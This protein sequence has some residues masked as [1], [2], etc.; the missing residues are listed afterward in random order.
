[1]TSC[2]WVLRDNPTVE[3]YLH[4]AKLV[5][6]APSG[7]VYT[8]GHGNTIANLVIHEHWNNSAQKRYSRN[9]GNNEGIKLN[10]LSGN[11]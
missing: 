3:N 10:F 6:V 1:M 5:A 9:L 11:S 7:T 8:D 4:E 2:N